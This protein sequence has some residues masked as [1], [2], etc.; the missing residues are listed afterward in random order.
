M[1][2]LLIW[3]FIQGLC[4]LACFAEPAIDCEVRLVQGV[5]VIIIEGNPEVN[6]LDVV[7]PIDPASYKRFGKKKMIFIWPTNLPIYPTLF[8]LVNGKELHYVPQLNGKDLE[9]T[10]SLEPV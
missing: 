10:K 5:R 3:L 1:K 7:T 2:T 4:C 8:F 9:P 6:A